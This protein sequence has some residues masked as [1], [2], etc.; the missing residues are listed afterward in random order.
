ME[1]ILLFK[2]PPKIAIEY[3]VFNQ[4]YKKCNNKSS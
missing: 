2:V 4:K 1:P 3:K